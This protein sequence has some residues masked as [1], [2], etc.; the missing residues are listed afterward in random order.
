MISPDARPETAPDLVGAVAVHEILH[1]ELPD[2]ADP[3]ILAH[4]PAAQV[5]PAEIKYQSW[6]NFCTDGIDPP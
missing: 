6:H 4:S 2:I 1:G 5:R 3:A